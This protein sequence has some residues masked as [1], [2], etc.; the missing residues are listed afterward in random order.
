MTMIMAETVKND[1]RDIVENKKAQGN[2]S[3]HEN[4]IFF[5]Q[6][7]TVVGYILLVLKSTV[8]KII[9]ETKKNIEK[10]AKRRDKLNKL[11][12]KQKKKALRR[13]R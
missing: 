4:L 11:K 12:Y 5:I 10:D 2:E 9:K 6:V 1:R 3:K 8:G 7:G 13:K